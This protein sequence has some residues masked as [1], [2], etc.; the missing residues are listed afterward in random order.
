MK[1]SLSLLSKIEELKAE[2]KRRMN[3]LVYLIRYNIR[4]LTKISKAQT[5]NRNR[6][7]R[8]TNTSHLFEFHPSTNKQTK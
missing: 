5:I 6:K 2:K 8:R 1:N 4:I 3:T 7:D